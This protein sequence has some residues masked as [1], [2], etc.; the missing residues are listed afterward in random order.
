MSETTAGGDQGLSSTPPR[1]GARGGDKGAVRGE[2]RVEKSA[3][4]SLGQ[5]VDF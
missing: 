3:F 2:A 1:E 5:E 4:L